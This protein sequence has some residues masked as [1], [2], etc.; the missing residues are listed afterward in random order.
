MEASAA[1]AFLL[2]SCFVLITQ[3]ISKSQTSEPETLLSCS[4]QVP[5][6]VSCKENDAWEGQTISNEDFL[7]THNHSTFRIEDPLLLEHLR[8]RVAALPKVYGYSDLEAAE[9]FPPYIYPH[10]SE[11]YNEDTRNWIALNYSTNQIEMHCEGEFPGMFLVGP[12]QNI[13]FTNPS[14]LRSYWTVYLYPGT[15]VAINSWIEWAIGSCHKS[16][17]KFELQFTEPRFRE[18]AYNRTKYF[19][20]KTLNESG[21]MRARPLIIAMITLDSF[22]R[23]HF[24]RKLPK[25]VDFLNTLEAEGTWK[26]FDFKI[27]N[28]VGTD[29]AENQAHL[30]GD[31]FNGYSPQSTLE[32]VGDLFGH[33]AIWYKLR[34]K[35]FISLLGMDACPYKLV[36]VIGRAPRADHI[37]N[38]FYCANTVYGGFS[39]KKKASTVQRCI[40]PVM[41]H[42]YLMNYTLAFSEKYQDLNQFAYNHLTAAHEQT[43]QH[44]ATLD[45]DL[46][47]YMNQYLTKFPES[48][49]V[50]YVVA[51]H[52]MRY[53]DFLFGT[54]AIQE[55]R[56]PV[57]FMIASHK[58]L[59]TIPNSYDTLHHN[60]QRLTTKGDLRRS[61]FYLA[62]RQYNQTID[63]SKIYIDLFSEK[64][65][66]TRICEDALIPEWYCS[67]YDLTP[68][69]K[70][71]Y[72]P[73]YPDYETRQPE[74]AEMG[75][76][77]RYLGPQV[78]SSLNDNVNSPF[79]RMPG[80]CQ[81]LT[82]R[83]VELVIYSQ[84]KT[85]GFT[86]SCQG[87]SCPQSTTTQEPRKLL[88]K[89]LLTV[90]QH[91]D[92]K[93][94]AWVL[95]SDLTNHETPPMEIENFPPFPVVFRNSK[96]FAKIISVWRA[97]RYGGACEEMARQSL[98]NPEHCV[99]T[100]STL[101]QYK[102]VSTAITAKA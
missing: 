14:E 7:A 51:D 95:L 47:W 29:T 76:L 37:V 61:V 69:S 32:A 85:A 13:T 67:A 34:K 16:P 1:K 71:A 53:G 90:T 68:L 73:T 91:P 15:P 30:F 33:D 92:V 22:S 39:S 19:Q 18:F 36:Q 74:E 88:L 48:D 42:W 98:L 63:S 102:E 4:E 94:D 86:S 2:L 52:G 17:T 83:S 31:K 72:D 66:D 40:G 9:L 5:L 100:E 3:L 27:H 41:S 80:L 43:G 44:A 79:H 21:A 77:I 82:L 81:K 24:F 10:C 101:A 26:V 89:L 70:L 11:S 58:H 93:L 65:A 12:H 55:H 23:R 56:L 54:S 99:C 50:M 87:L 35:G 45:D 25:S 60:T 20:T 6:G 28:I 97:D 64:A 49:L 84:I 46:V 38:P 96:L 59:K 8:E 78:I 75:A 62:A 57:F